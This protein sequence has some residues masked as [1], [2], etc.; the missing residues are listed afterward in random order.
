MANKI[1]PDRPITA[2]KIFASLTDIRLVGNG[3][4]SVRFI[5]FD[6]RAHGLSSKTPSGHYYEQHGRDLHAFINALELENF[7]LGGWSFGCLATLSE[8]ASFQPLWR[9]PFLSG[10]VP[11]DRCHLNGLAMRD[12]QPAYVTAVAAS[13][14]AD[15]WRK[16]LNVGEHVLGDV[17]LVT[18]QFLH[19]QR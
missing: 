16:C 13:D 11:E 18:H 9:P 8:R 3:L 1:N 17:I 6:P 5:S 12:G 7:I 19:V 14:V 2:A 4:P 15:G 10:L